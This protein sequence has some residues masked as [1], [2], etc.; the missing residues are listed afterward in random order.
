MIGLDYPA[1]YQVADTMGLEMSLSLL[2]KMQL[3]EGRVIA[4]SRE[5]KE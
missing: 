5:R 1:L 3:L 2:R 4:K